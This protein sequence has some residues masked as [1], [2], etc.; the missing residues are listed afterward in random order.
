LKGSRRAARPLLRKPLIVKEGQNWPA[1]FGVAGTTLIPT[2]GH[3][4]AEILLFP[5][6]F[7]SRLPPVLSAA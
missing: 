7:C 2:A 5:K 6:L 3:K 4:K 1:I